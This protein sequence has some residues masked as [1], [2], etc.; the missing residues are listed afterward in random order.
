LLFESLSIDMADLRGDFEDVGR[1]SLLLLMFESFCI[2]IVDLRGDFE[3][4]VRRMVV[5]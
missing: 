4:A 5:L 2:D 1:R 3:D